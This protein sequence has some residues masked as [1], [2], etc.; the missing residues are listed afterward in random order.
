MK[1]QLSSRT[2]DFLKSQ[3]DLKG[4][5]WAS[6]VSSFPFCP[7]ALF[8]QSDG[9]A[10]C[11]QLPDPGLGCSWGIPARVGAAPNPQPELSRVPW[12]SRAPPWQFLF[13]DVAEGSFSSTFP[14]HSHGNSPAVPNHSPVHFT[15]LV[16]LMVPLT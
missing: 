13:Q 16:S 1:L 4:C 11:S 14:V 5:S 10:G 15:G 7:S 12:A 2:T 8:Q 6:F 9:L 3:I